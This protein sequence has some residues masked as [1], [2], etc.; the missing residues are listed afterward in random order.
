MKPKE[1]GHLPGC[2]TKS[3]A[4]MVKRYRME[5]GEDDPALARLEESDLRFS[6]CAEGCPILEKRIQRG[7]ELAQK[8]GW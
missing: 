4:K 5:S 8:H 7:I 6:D 3:V 1:L 2:K